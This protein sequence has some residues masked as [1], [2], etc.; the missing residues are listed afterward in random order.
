[1]RALHLPLLEVALQTVLQRLTYLLPRFPSLLLQVLFS[2]TE[3]IL[4]K[5]FHLSAQLQL[6]HP[7]PSYPCSEPKVQNLKLEA[8]KEGVG[9]KRRRAG[10]PGT[11]IKSTFQGQP[12][13]AGPGQSP[14]NIC[15]RQPGLFT[16]GGGAEHAPFRQS[17]PL[18]L[19]FRTVRFQLSYSVFF[20]LVDNNSSIIA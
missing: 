12:E 5:L 11:L 20:L 2:K 19:G 6:V 8:G 16:A 17:L 7:P 9:K 18:E 4:A 13:T 10:F 1:M 15:K 3:P 14:R